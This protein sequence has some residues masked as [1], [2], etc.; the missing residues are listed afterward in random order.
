MKRTHTHTHTHAHTHTLSLSLSLSLS[1]THTLTHTYKHTYT[2]KLC[3]THKTLSLKHTYT[4]THTHTTLSL[5]Y[6]HTHTHTNT[7]THTLSLSLSDITCLRWWGGSG[8]SGRGDGGSS[9]VTPDCG[10]FQV[11]A[12][13]DGPALMSAR[14]QRPSSAVTA[15]VIQPDQPRPAAEVRLVKRLPSVPT[16]SHLYSCLLTPPLYSCT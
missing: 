8:G 12:V 3:L 4:H 15:D 5:K 7:H 11:T 10:V 14:R 1:H 2:H 16:Y 9:R 6:T 13:V